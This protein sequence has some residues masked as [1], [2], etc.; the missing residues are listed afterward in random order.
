MPD[1]KSGD[2]LLN[3]NSLTVE[4]ILLGHVTNIKQKI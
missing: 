3:K 4:L 2:N 1:N